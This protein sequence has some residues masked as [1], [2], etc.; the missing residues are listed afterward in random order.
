[1]NLKKITL[2]LIL[3]SAFISD[4]NATKNFEE[5][6]KENPFKSRTPSTY[7]A[8]SQMTVYEDLSLEDKYK[9]N[10]RILGQDVQT[11]LKKMSELARDENFEDAQLF[12]G[13]YYRLSHYTK[14]NLE[15][16]IDWY[17]LAAKNHDSS[18]A[19]N[20]LGIIFHAEGDYDKAKENYTL[21]GEKG[22]KSAISNL[23]QLEEDYRIF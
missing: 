7:S 16:A 12:M 20:S 22:S 17:S 5:E 9:A 10:L 14:E 21:A 1:M 19:Y 6:Y 3:C 13:E 4:A 18:R 23:K 11:S 8:T 15:Q 2:G